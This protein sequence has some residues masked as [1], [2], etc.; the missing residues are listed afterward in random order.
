MSKNQIYDIAIIG[1]G[2]SGL[3]CASRFQHLKTCIIDS[4]DT[5]GAK[6]KVSGGGRCNISN[7]YLSSNNYCGDKNFIASVFD[8]FDNNKLFY[9]LKSNNVSITLR[10]KLVKGAY[11]CKTSSE[12]INMFKTITSKTRYYLDCKVLDVDCKNEIFNIKTS[13]SIIKTRRLVVSSGGLSYPQLNSSDIGYK[14]AQNFGHTI[15]NP[16]P[17]L[18][19]WTTQKE[20][21]AFRELSGVSLNLVEIKVGD[22]VCKG[23]LLFTHKG[24]SGPA[25]LT[26]SLYWDKGS[27]SINFLPNKNISLPKRFKQLAKNISINLEDYQLSPAGNFGYSKAEVTKGGINTNDIDET[28]QSKLQKNLYFT[29]EVLDIT[30]ELGGYNL[31]WAFSSGYCAIKI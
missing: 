27:I 31:Q 24:M 13:Q 15:I 14:I 25:V 19:G 20:Q 5:I 17:A 21:F 4:N 23:G 8:K 12:I 3:M 1:A 6:I 7:K 30:G 2:A 11:F 18:V 26:A 29:G 22:K 16:K 9:F 10:E 28:M